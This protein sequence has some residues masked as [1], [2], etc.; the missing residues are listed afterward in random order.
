MGVMWKVCLLLWSETEMIRMDNTQNALAKR[1]FVTLE[2]N[3]QN[4]H[5]SDPVETNYNILLLCDSGEAEFEIN[6]QRI[7]VMKRT[8]VIVSQVMMNRLIRVS[9]DF[10]GRILVMKDE[11]SLD[12]SMGLPIE[13]LKSVFSAT[14][15]QVTDDAE[16]AILS[17]FM[18]NIALYDRL[19]GT[20][21]AL[22]MVGSIWRCMLIVMAEIE[23]H[24][25][26]TWDKAS[27]TMGDTYFRKFIAFIK[28]NLKCEHE[29]SF[30]AEKLSITPKYLS[31]ICKQKTGYKA[32][33]II[34]TMLVAKL[35][36]D[37]LL[38][39]ESLKVIA[40]DYRFADQSSLGKF[41]KKMTGV[42]PSIFKRQNGMPP[43]DVEV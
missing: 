31:E 32:K 17:N 33:E 41:F 27:Y 28:E 42:S 34:S 16:W 19:P 18:T 22:D 15:Y 1:G 39:G 4:I 13:L 23:A 12:V 3:A 43:L 7:R 26:N 29:V 37:I 30:Y 24:D 2:V 36:R 21:Y 14:V 38:S 40:Y 6:M 25:R 8:R 5:I 20:S 9:P 10:T 11:F 35:K